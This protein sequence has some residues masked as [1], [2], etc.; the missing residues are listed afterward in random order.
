MAWQDRHY[1]REGGGTTGSRLMWLLTGSVPLFSIFGVRVRMHASMIVFV[2]FELLTSTGPTG[3]G[4]RN[5]LTAMI[6]L[7]ASVLLH[8]FGHIYGSR[9]MG[10]R[11]NDILI[12]PLG[13]LAYAEPPQRPW[14]CLITTACGPLVNI[15]I[16]L[17]TGVIL[18]AAS[19]TEQ[20]IPW[21]PFATGLK[22]F[23]PTTTFTYYV[24][25]VFLVN[26]ALAAFNLLMV[27]YP[28][29]GGRIV[30]ELLWFKFGY[31]RSMMFATAVGMVGA[32][33]VAMVGLAYLSLL[34]VLIAGFG[35]HTCFQQRAQLKQIGPGEFE[36]EALYAS[37]YEPLTP[38]RRKASRW[39]LRRAHKH[40]RQEREEQKAIDIILARVSAHGMNSLTWFERRALRRATE[41]QRAR[42]DARV[43]RVA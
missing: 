30:Q 3:L 24:F 40:A 21:F 35:F 17:V 11:G 19:R 43:H 29:D 26:Y 41:R 31:Y 13:G 1:Y 37:A 36:S 33:I 12:W 27:F 2:A 9:A 18:L 6:I 5:A 7:F 28:F 16:C 22:S 14:P 39:A 32:A 4:P 15:L 25:W 20:G 42:D 38:K 34:L 10:G 23:I 8:E